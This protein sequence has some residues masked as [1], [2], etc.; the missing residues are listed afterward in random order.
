MSNTN[1]KTMDF[2]DLFDNPEYSDITIKLEHG[3]LNAHRIVLSRGSE[4]FK[5]L[6]K[7]R[8][9][10]A[11]EGVITFPDHSDEIIR[12][13]VAFLYGIK[14]AISTL[15]SD[16]WV[17]L[18]HF[19]HYIEASQLVDQTVQNPPADF[20]PSAFIIL[21]DQLDMPILTSKGIRKFFMAKEKKSHESIEDMCSLDWDV[22][23][24]MHKQWLDQRF[25]PWTLLEL[26]CHFCAEN[27]TG[28]DGVELLTRFIVHIEVSQFTY[29]QLL[30]C[31]QFPIIMESQLLSHLF[32]NMIKLKPVEGYS[33]MSSL[34]Q[35]LTARRAMYEPKATSDDIPD[36]TMMNFA[37]IPNARRNQ[38]L[39]P[40]HVNT[41]AVQGV[42]LRG[43]ARKRN[44]F[45]GA[46]QRDAVQ[47]DELADTVPPSD[48]QSNLNRTT[49]DAMREWN[50]K[51][52]DDILKD[53]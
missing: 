25:D 36:M 30:E 13:V 29:S 20:A 6:L 3:S 52:I 47:R 1:A 15:S 41:D 26:D 10:E 32:M 5:R 9:A 53:L 38:F 34:Q 46:M 18:L 23:S 21:G 11:I 43:V 31:L 17:K 40:S 24:R 22:Y 51:E 16:N 7:S 42:T 35:G 4:V 33:G 2:K 49:N 50:Q 19:A 45:E 28:N 27:S 48:S 37:N 12:V 14:P 39:H 8:M 44:A